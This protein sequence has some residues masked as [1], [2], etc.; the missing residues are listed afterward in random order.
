LIPRFDRTPKFVGLS[1]SRASIQ[2][3]STGKKASGRFEGD[4]LNVKRKVVL[5]VH[6][7]VSA[8]RMQIERVK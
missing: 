6:G 4:I 1:K 7:T 2:L 5:T 8:T 3:D